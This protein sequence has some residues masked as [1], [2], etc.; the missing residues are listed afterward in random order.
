VIQDFPWPGSAHIQ[1][2]VI[3]G[4]VRSVLLECCC[5]EQHVDHFVVKARPVETARESYEALQEQH[6][7]HLTRNEEALRAYADSQART[8]KQVRQSES[9]AWLQKHADC[10]SSVALDPSLN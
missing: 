2:M 1:C 8:A 3:D 10:L 6:V 7:A 4:A 5:G 9:F